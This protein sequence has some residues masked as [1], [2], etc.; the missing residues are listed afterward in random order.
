MK[1]ETFKNKKKIIFFS[2]LI[3][4][5]FV[6]INSDFQFIENF[7]YLNGLVVYLNGYYPFILILS[8]IFIFVYYLYIQIMEESVV[9]HLKNGK[10]ILF[11]NCV[12]S[13]ILIISILD[14]KYTI[15]KI[16]LD[17]IDS[18]IAK[19]IE[20]NEKKLI[21]KM[22]KKFGEHNFLY[23]LIINKNKT[24]VLMYKEN[25]SELI[26]KLN[27]EEALIQKLTNK[28]INISNLNN[29]NLILD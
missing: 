28:D 3:I 20:K 16:N 10:L 8:S 29:I 1:D 25:E 18:S 4:S 19:L 2:I 13:F 9:K 12:I 26:S 24:V 6:F 5:F 17:K 22:N 11:S 14:Y 21:I 7:N 27:I 23:Y 15:K